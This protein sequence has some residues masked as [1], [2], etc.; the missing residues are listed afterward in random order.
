MTQ[1]RSKPVTIL[2]VARAAGMAKSTVSRA[3]T[4]RDYVAPETRE[5]VLRVAQE[6]GFNPNPHAR[7]LSDGRCLNTVALFSLYLYQ[8]TNLE[9]IQHIQNLLRSEGYDAPLHAYGIH[10]ESNP[11]NQ[12]A[13]LSDLRQSRP[14]SILV[15]TSGLNS[16]SLDELR[17]YRD[18]G[19]IV[20]CYDEVVDL[21]CD[22]VIFD[23]A[24]NTYQAARHLLSLGHRRIG[25]LTTDDAT[26]LS[27]RR[28]GFERA[29]REA[30]LQARPEWNFPPSGGSFEASGARRAH[31]YMSLPARDRPTGLCIVNDYAA[32]TFV[33]EV[34]RAGL[35]VPRDVSIVSHDD[36][37]IAPYCPVPL[38][39]VSHPAKEI[40]QAVIDLLKQRLEA[41]DQAAP[42]RV[43]LKG[44]LVIRDS[45]A[46]HR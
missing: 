37:A 33:T 42:R 29:L 44:E 19:G 25:L 30:G 35:A 11:V 43:E 36:S 45:A 8:G 28:I 20:V 40:A 34:M 2:D 31:M 24:D 6:L 9:K 21:E 46:P 13:L 26:A 4:G 15:N 22:Q 32:L 12:R 18:E 10:N 17:R 27:P 16:D 3:L 39:T 7:R 38:T 23:R 5:T 14:R 1:N 41:T